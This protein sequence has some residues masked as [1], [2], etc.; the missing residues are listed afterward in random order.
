MEPVIWLVTGVTTF[1]AALLAQRHPRARQVGRLALATLFL[2]GG[3]LVNGLYLLGGTDY[4]DFADA[5]YLPFVTETWR[6]VVAPTQELWIGLLVLFEATVG[7]LVLLPGRA[8]QVGL[9]AAMVFHV[10]L[11]PFGWFFSAWSIPM[12]VALALLLRA[13]RQV[14]AAP[15]DAA[16]DVVAVQ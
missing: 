14:A 4:A 3:A 9:V 12:L 13:E 1:V 10:L 2:A 11:L 5:S 7:V 15:T 8:V 16:R 6:A